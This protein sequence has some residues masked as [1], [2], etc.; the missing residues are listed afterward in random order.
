VDRIHAP[1]KWYSLGMVT[2]NIKVEVRHDGGRTSEDDV[3]DLTPADRISIMWQLAMD[4]WAFKGD[5]DAESRL[6]RHVVRV[7]RGR[8]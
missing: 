5:P 1:G 2:R 6:P 4:A 8:G 7:I 3:R